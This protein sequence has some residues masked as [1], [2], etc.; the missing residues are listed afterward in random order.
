MTYTIMA[1]GILLAVANARSLRGAHS[2]IFASPP[3]RSLLSVYDNKYLD[4]FTDDRM[5]QCLV[6]TAPHTLYLNDESRGGRR[7][8]P[9]IYTDLLAKDMAQFVDGG[10]ITWKKSERDAARKKFEAKQSNTKLC[11]VTGKSQGKCKKAW[12]ALNNGRD[13]TEINRDVNYLT[14]SERKHFGFMKALH[15]AKRRCAKLSTGKSVPQLSV[16]GLH[17]DVHGMSDKTAE[18]I[19]QHFVIGTRAMETID[20]KRRHYD[21]RKSLKFRKAMAAKLNGVPK[22]ICIQQ[23]QDRGSA[24]GIGRSGRV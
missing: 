10:Y 3:E 14:N 15:R 8:K 20:N 13:P 19:G 7:K 1:A 22:D 16:G 9:E 5:K 18:E 23:N 17:V 12:A 2:L 4:T 11:G 21:K 6:F 24:S